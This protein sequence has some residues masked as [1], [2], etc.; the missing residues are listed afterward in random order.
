MATLLEQALGAAVRLEKYPKSSID[1][2]VTVLE[3]DGGGAYWEAH[4]IRE[5]K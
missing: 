5:D 3:D 1:V 4:Q 2:F